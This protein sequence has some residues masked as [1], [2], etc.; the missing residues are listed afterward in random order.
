MPLHDYCFREEFPKSSSSS[1]DSAAGLS[2][3]TIDA[4]IWLNEGSLRTRDA[5]SSVLMVSEED[6]VDTVGGEVFEPDSL[7]VVFPCWRRNSKK[8]N[9]E[10]RSSSSITG[11]V[12]SPCWSIPILEKQ[13]GARL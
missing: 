5:L 3:E 2:V 11:I 6:S 7:A 9:H 8:S 13:S 4:M 12:S 1:D 10:S